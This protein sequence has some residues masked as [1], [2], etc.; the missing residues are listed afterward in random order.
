MTEPDQAAA[1]ARDDRKQDEETGVPIASLYGATTYVSDVRKLAQLFALI[2]LLILYALSAWLY[3]AGARS[4]NQWNELHDNGVHVTARVVACLGLLGGSGSNAAG[5]S[6]TA[7]FYLDGQ[8]H[9]DHLPGT[10]EFTFHQLVPVVVARTDPGLIALARTLPDQKAS[11]GVF[12]LPTVLLVLAVAG[13]VVLAIDHRR[14]KAKRA[15]QAAA[16]PP[17]PEPSDTPGEPVRRPSARETAFRAGFLGPRP[18]MEEPAP[19]PRTAR[20]APAG[21]PASAAEAAQVAAAAAVQA[22]E[23]AE[24]AARAAA[25]AAQAAEAARAAEEG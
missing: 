13:S 17:E 7:A 19:A 9:V 8:R 21:P 11:A 5:Y 22:A 3:V 14:L 16:A 12:V 20:A 24:A 25:A 10:T 18:T 15:A 2:G 1:D 4:N 23:A 6:C